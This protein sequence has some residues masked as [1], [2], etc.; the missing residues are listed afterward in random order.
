MPR[1]THNKPTNKVWRTRR[2]IRVL[3]NRLYTDTELKLNTLLK[4]IK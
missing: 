1:T 2:N 4:G 3:K